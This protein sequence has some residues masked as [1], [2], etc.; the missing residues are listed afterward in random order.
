MLMIGEFVGGYIA[1]SLAIMTDAAHLLSDLAGFFFSIFAIWIGKKAK[2]KTFTFGFHRS[3]ALGALASIMLIWVLTAILLYEA[4]NRFIY[5]EFHIE[6]LVMMIVAIS[7]L[8]INLSMAKILHSAPGGHGHSHGGKS[9][10]GHGGSKKKSHNEHAGHSHGGGKA[11]GG[12]GAKNDNN[13]AETQ[14]ENK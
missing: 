3:Q 11:C 7:G 6:P 4:I 14:H 2:T 10:G 1:H 5:R 8:L 12:H 13:T 9:C